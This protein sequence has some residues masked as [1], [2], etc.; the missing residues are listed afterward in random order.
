MSRP[1]VCYRLSWSKKIHDHG[2]LYVTLV[3]NKRTRKILK[4][5]NF[6]LIQANTVDQRPAIM[7]KCFG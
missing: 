2:K 6:N 4:R 5:A 1:P 3:L 7:W